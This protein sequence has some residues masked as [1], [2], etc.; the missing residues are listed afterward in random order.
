MHVQCTCTVPCITKK[1]THTVDC[2]YVFLFV[3]QRCN[4]PHNLFD[5]KGATWELNRILV[6][7]KYTCTR[8]INEI[9]RDVGRSVYSR[10]SRLCVRCALSTS[11]YMY[12]YG[13]CVHVC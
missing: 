4:D 3:A 13:V 2:V 9:L 1:R 11:I 12:T 8:N 5:N 7:Q 6:L 10:Q